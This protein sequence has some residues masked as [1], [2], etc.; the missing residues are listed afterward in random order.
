M[1]VW[2]RKIEPVLL[3]QSSDV[4]YVVTNDGVRLCFDNYYGLQEDRFGEHVLSF[5][6]PRRAIRRRSTKHF[7]LHSFPVT[8][9]FSDVVKLD[10][11]AK[12]GA[13]ILQ[14]KS[15]TGPWRR[16]SLFS[17]EYLLKKHRD[18]E[19]AATRLARLRHCYVTYGHE[20]PSQLHAVAETTPIISHYDWVKT[21][22]TI[23]DSVVQTDY[24]GPNWVKCAGRFDIVAYGFKSGLEEAKRAISD[25]GIEDATFTW[26]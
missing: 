26:L 5:K 9:P 13:L 25:I 2:F 4:P 16:I 22:L 17:A 23:A 21:L 14:D 10:R 18:I 12:D 20:L 24:R 1:S 6:M 11:A 7:R 19:K 8:I 3:H 15:F